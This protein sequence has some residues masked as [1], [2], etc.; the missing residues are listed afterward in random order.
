VGSVTRVEFLIE[1]IEEGTRL[2][3]IEEPGIVPR[4]GSLEASA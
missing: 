2:T 3:V 1:P 4:E